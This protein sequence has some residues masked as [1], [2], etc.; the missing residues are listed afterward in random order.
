MFAALCVK[1]NFVP[2]F[3]PAKTLTPSWLALLVEPRFHS[4]L[5]GLFTRAAF[6]LHLL[7][8]SA[9]IQHPCDPLSIQMRLQAV[10]SLLSQN[11]VHLSPAL[12]AAVAAEEPPL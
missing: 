3:F 6:L 8:T 4:T 2:V 10:F 5:C 12:T 11:G 1:M 7:K 9:C